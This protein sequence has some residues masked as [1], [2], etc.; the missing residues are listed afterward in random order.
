MG[1]SISI[2][3]GPD[4][5]VWDLQ[6]DEQ[7]GEKGPRSVLG[8]QRQMLR[9]LSHPPLP[10]LPSVPQLQR[11]PSPSP[12]QNSSFYRAVNAALRGS[13]WESFVPHSVCRSPGVAKL[14]STARHMGFVLFHLFGHLQSG[15]KGVG[16]IAER[17]ANRERPRGRQGEGLEARSDS[18]RERGRQ[19]NGMRNR[20]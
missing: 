11:G 14:L 8:L 9:A 2:L 4:G 7:K 16:W 10:A 1:K 12:A 15:K 5:E 18:W 6:A 17:Q 20:K 3:W 19:I 13:N